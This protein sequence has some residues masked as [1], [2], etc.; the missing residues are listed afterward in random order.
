MI[1]L[2]ESQSMRNSVA[3]GRDVGDELVLKRSYE[4][5]HDAVA[6]GAL[7]ILLTGTPM[8]TTP[9]NVLN[10]LNLLPRYTTDGDRTVGG[11]VQFA[12]EQGVDLESD[13]LDEDEAGKR[14]LDLLKT[15]IPVLH[16]LTDEFVLRWYGEG[17]G[18]GNIGVP[19][20]ETLM[21]KPT[22]VRH[23]VPFEPAKLRETLREL[24][25]GVLQGTRN[26]VSTTSAVVAAR[27]QLHGEGTTGILSQLDNI[28]MALHSSAAA[29]HSTL[30]RSEAYKGFRERDA[31]VRRRALKP[32]LEDLKRV[33]DGPPEGDAKFA[34]LWN[35]IQRHQREKTI[36][37]VNRKETALDLER[38]L[39]LCGL[40]AA[41]TFSR[42]AHEKI[43]EFDIKQQESL[44][45]RFAPVAYGVRSDQFGPDQALAVLI[46]MDKNGAGIN[47]QDAT[48]R[49]PDSASGS[50][51]NKAAARRLA[52]RQVLVHYD[53]A[54]TSA[55]GSQQREWRPNRWKD[56]P[57]TLHVYSFALDT[58]VLDAICDDDTAAV[59]DKV[60]KQ[61]LKL[62]RRLAW[63]SDL[64]ARGEPSHAM[65]MAAWTAS[66]AAEAK[67][68][69][70]K[71]GIQAPSAPLGD[72]CTA[73]GLA[74]IESPHVV[75]LVQHKGKAHLLA[76]DFD[77]MCLTADTDQQ[78][79]ED[80]LRDAAEHPTRAYEAAHGPQK[81][82]DRRRTTW[83]RE[84]WVNATQQQL[85]KR[86]GAGA[87]AAMRAWANRS[88][89]SWKDL[90]DSPAEAAAAQV[91]THKA[92]TLLVPRAWHA[93]RD[94][95]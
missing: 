77:A 42:S 86:M 29:L 22:T 11:W 76:W 89:L 2:D 87:W 47:L 74:D 28:L 54:T 95:A 68:R 92:F 30:T 59:I 5:I 19:F 85:E 81:G 21:Y 70:L 44:F 23:D 26:S 56:A 71:M 62:E 15:K 17:D 6:R 83:R 16:P 90:Q 45:K 67:D 82:A 94:A 64:K 10:Q 9:K 31:N 61:Q 66:K 63:A 35:I 88:G 49:P 32:W 65:A 79:W 7:I 69:A 1:V 72:F 50:P 84:D 33:V 36:V 4:A 25:V 27:K 41:C 13:G 14:I 12:K 60:K 20:G 37:F 24:S 46:L 8:S 38:R 93:A 78:F 91:M 43:I 52:P 80:K 40:K 58:A 3:G 39:Q 57:S 55:I 51:H 48:V 75:V 18:H 73:I 34:A 53:P